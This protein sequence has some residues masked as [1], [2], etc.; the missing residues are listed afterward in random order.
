M[1]DLLFHA[2]P[3]QASRCVQANPGKKFFPAPFLSSVPVLCSRGKVREFFYPF[4]EY[5]W[6]H[7]SMLPTGMVLSLRR[8]TGGCKQAQI[9]EKQ[10]HSSARGQRLVRVNYFRSQKLLLPFS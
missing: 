4:Q 8:T 3:S 9:P 6:D 10:K 5:R 7:H 1:Q 2:L